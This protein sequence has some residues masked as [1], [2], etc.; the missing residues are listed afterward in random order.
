MLEK[1]IKKELERKSRFNGKSAAFFPAS[2]I[3]LV[4]RD[5]FHYFLAKSIGSV[6]GFTFSTC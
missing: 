5:I 1:D 6:I 3:S 2:E 4:W